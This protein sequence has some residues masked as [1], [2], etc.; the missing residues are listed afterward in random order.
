MHQELCVMKIVQAFQDLFDYVLDI[1]IFQHY[2]CS[3]LRHRRMIPDES[4]VQVIWRVLKDQEDS[5][6]DIEHVIEFD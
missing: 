2:G 1:F 5:F 4:R 3:Q 6:L